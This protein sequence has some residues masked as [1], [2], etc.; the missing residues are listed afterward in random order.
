[1]NIKAVV[2]FTFDNYYAY[3]NIPEVAISGV[4]ILND[5]V[6]MYARDY[7]SFLSIIIQSVVENTNSEWV[8]PFDFRTMAQIVGY[9]ASIFVAPRISPFY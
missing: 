4:S 8:K 3:L 5:K 6:G 9:L 7:D 1:M 2:N